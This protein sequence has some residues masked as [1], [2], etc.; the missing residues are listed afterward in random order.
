MAMEMGMDA[1]EAAAEEEAER[2]LAEMN[3]ALF[4]KRKKST[5]GSSNNTNQS[6]S[7][8]SDSRRVRAAAAASLAALDAEMNNTR[9]QLTMDDEDGSTLTGTSTTV[10]P[11]ST[12]RSH[13]HSLPSS[14][15]FDSLDLTSG[16]SSYSMLLD[17]LTALQDGQGMGGALDIEGNVSSSATSKDDGSNSGSGGASGSMSLLARFQ[18]DERVKKAM[19]E[20][21]DLRLYARQIETELEEYEEKCI[22]DYLADGDNLA[23]LHNDIL[24]CDSIL[25]NMEGMLQHF[26]SD[27][28]AISSEIHSLQE[29]SYGMNVK[30][31]NYKSAEDHL[32][33]FI[34][35]S[36]ISEELAKVLLEGEV[37]SEAWV[38]NLKELDGKIAFL[39]S[40]QGRHA[41]NVSRQGMGG[42]ESQVQ[43]TTT[44]SSSSSGSG[45]GS[46]TSHSIIPPSSTLAARDMLPLAHKL[47]LRCLSRIRSFLFER[48]HSLKKPKTNIQ[49]KQK[50]L[51]KY[52]PMYAFLLRHTP[53][54]GEMAG[55]QRTPATS[56]SGSTS[57]LYASP[58]SSSTS[59]ATPSSST[60]P[61]SSPS[62]SSSS[63][64]DL[65]E[66]IR[67]VY[68]ET[69]SAIYV[70]KFKKYLQ[71]LKKIQS[72]EG[73]LEK[74]DTIGSGGGE[75]S[76]G[77]SGSSSSNSG[78]GMFGG[79]FSSASSSS[80][81]AHHAA[82]LEN[83]FRLGG[84]EGVLQMN[85]SSSAASG[86]SGYE[87]LLSGDDVIIPH[88][89][90]S[91]G[92]A[93]VVGSGSGSGSGVGSTASSGSASSSSSSA[94][95]PFDRTFKSA[96]LLLMDTA[97]GEYDFIV[98]FFGERMRNDIMERAGLLEEE[99][100]REKMEEE[101]QKEKE[102]AVGA[103]S[104]SPSPAAAPSSSSSASTSTSERGR[105]L[106]H[107]HSRDKALFKLVFEPTIELF[108]EH[109]KHFISNCHDSLQLL[110]IIR[111][112]CQC[113]LLMQWRRCHALDATFDRMNMMLWPR[114]KTVFDANVESVMKV[115]FCEI[116]AGKNKPHYIGTRY[117][118]FASGILF[119]NLDYG[120]DILTANL[121]RLRVEV[122]KFFL[123]SASR[124]P[125]PK[126]QLIFLINN[127]YNILNI[128]TKAGF[129]TGATGASTGGVGGATIGS[130]GNSGPFS[131]SSSPSLAASTS[132][133]SS[134]AG[135]NDE[136]L[137][138]SHQLSSH[139]SL[140]V[141]E[142]LSEQFHSLI[143]WVKQIE[144]I[145]ASEERQAATSGRQ[146]NAAN[147][148]KQ[149]DT[150]KLKQIVDSFSKYWK[151]GIETMNKNVKRNFGA[152]ETNAGGTKQGASSASSSSSTSSSSSSSSSS[153]ALHIFMQVLSQLV[154]YYQRFQTLLSKYVR[155]PHHHRTITSGVVSIS[156]IMIEIKKYSTKL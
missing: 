110:I 131:S 60:A 97:L 136:A 134:S 119:L 151:E 45:G 3:A 33:T 137:Y 84:R 140:Y 93:G 106:L 19:E 4:S 95:F 28:A 43:I 126:L 133:S 27:L 142:E 96:L 67:R 75:D 138:W 107:P 32:H 25:S 112:V 150:N 103:S 2:Q 63:L 38:E 46:G 40:Q 58:S 54:H 148:A 98:H 77:K 80:R 41:A 78:G 20:G 51:M 31:R 135:E 149:I 89:V 115:P 73:M 16:S 13:P 92:A 35:C 37:S 104:A 156:N 152:D 18:Q 127:Y 141:E 105:E 145:Q 132:T 146:P 11:T 29:K 121:R 10:G 48:F 68:H 124:A 116:K 61:S 153:P 9:A 88:L 99:V 36:Y 114:F 147:V 71:E 130:G 111:I 70:G 39:T 81:R 24:R 14:S 5:V 143:A 52:A 100:E 74:G 42:G 15:S 57:N 125:T 120:D 7:E 53:G 72:V 155:D 117:A 55:H 26:Q 102:R 8:E 123:R 23:A 1:V 69:M 12:S 65:A 129:G 62:S 56:R 50:V 108:L 49:I 94:R 30:L 64:P 87:S 90:G 17:P 21:V 139:V 22:Q 6:G 86:G 47:S 101:K 44:S 76:G 34:A 109:L 113:N 91:T 154:I 128:L 82:I 59:A 122:D 118:D 66:E 79:F 85:P 83:A 144:S